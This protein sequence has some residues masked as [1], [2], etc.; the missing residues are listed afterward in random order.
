LGKIKKILIANRGEIA[1]R[2]LKS[3][4]ELGMKTVVIYSSFD[5]DSLPVTSADESYLLRGTEVSE[6][7]LDIPQILQIA[8]SAKVDAIHPGY[9]FLSE[10]PDFAAACGKAKIKFIGPSVKTLR[11]LGDKVA[12]KQ[13][14]QKAKLPVVS[15]FAGVLPK[16]KELEK[17]ARDIGFPILVKAA[18]GGGGKG[19][20]IVKDLQSLEEAVSSAA[21]EAQAFFK[22]DRVFLEK[23][24]SHPR[25]IEV[26]I[27]GDEKGNVVHLFEREC[28]LQ[29]RHQKMMEESPSPSITSELREAI[30]AAAVKLAVAAKYSSAGTVEFLLDSEDRFYFLEVN[31]RLQVEHPVT[32][33]I[34]GI[35]LVKEQFRI[36]EGKTLCFSQKKIRQKG[37]AMECRLYAEDPEN[38]FLPAEGRVGVLRQP[39]GRGIRIDGALQEGQPIHPIYDPMLAKLIVSGKSREEVLKKMKDV[40]G[41]FTLLGIRHN[42]D[43]LRFILQTKPV[44]VGHYHTHTVQEFTEEFLQRRRFPRDVPDAAFV[45]AAMV[46]RSAPATRTDAKNFEIIHLLRGFR[47]A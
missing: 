34:T 4:R 38:Q 27:L 14:A 41:E 8:R 24:I 12:A 36:A 2:I 19:M 16:G 1:M 21:R 28:S 44:A 10:N 18:A 47:N 17:I 30:C 46:Q 32:E 20:R 23:Y 40:L 5:R 42:L 31:A 22:D 35:D 25:H 37:H 45:V 13:L 11:L 39:K 9:G 15:G 43:F 3:A 33:S 29:R 26:Q 7:Y 6:T